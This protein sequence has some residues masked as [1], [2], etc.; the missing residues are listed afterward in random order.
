MEPQSFPITVCVHACSTLGTEAWALSM[1]AKC[2]PLSYTST[3]HYGSISHFKRDENDEALEIPIH[4]SRQWHLR[5]P[6][7]LWT[8]LNSM[9]CRQIQRLKQSLD[10]VFQFHQEQFTPCKAMCGQH[11]ASHSPIVW[12][13]LLFNA[14]QCILLRLQ[15]GFQ[16]CLSPGIC[17]CNSARV[18]SSHMEM[19]FYRS[20]HRD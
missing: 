20:H 12:K 7:C 11:S 5:N 17:G 19:S 2:L 4:N 8:P 13:L 3:R 6:K 16:A 18:P 10:T 14:H 1:L 9:S 15:H